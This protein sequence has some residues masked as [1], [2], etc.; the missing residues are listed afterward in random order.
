M[1]ENRMRLAG[2]RAPEKNYI[3]LF[4]FAIG[5][6]SAARAEYR[7]QTGDA[8]RVSSPVAAIDV[9]ATDYGANE[10]LRG[11]VQLIGRFGTTEHSKCA[12]AAR[13]NL[14][15]DPLDDQIESF[16][17]SEAANALYRMQRASFLPTD[18]NAR[19]Q[20]VPT[21]DIAHVIRWSRSKMRAFRNIST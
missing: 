17:P 9:V 18:D 14:T 20:A 16:V 7:R 4:H 1:E 12:R 10:F 15:L 13:R 6:R 2:V 21:I 3:R 11:I 19:W 5:T 8:R